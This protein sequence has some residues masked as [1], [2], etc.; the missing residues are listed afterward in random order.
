MGSG[1]LPPEKG[2][3]PRDEGVSGLR[4]VALRC[5]DRLQVVGYEQRCQAGVD[6]EPTI[7]LD[8]GSP[9]FH[10]TGQSASSESPENL[11]RVVVDP[12]SLPVVAGKAPDHCRL[13]REYVVEIWHGE[14]EVAQVVGESAC[15]GA[16]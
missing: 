3:C 1:K 14:L 4:T 15:L 11:R 13:E 8:A 2:E 7:E 16:G 12:H 5:R 10:A 9:P 6:D